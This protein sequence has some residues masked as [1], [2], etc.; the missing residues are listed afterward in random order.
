MAVLVNRQLFYLEVNMDKTKNNTEELEMTDAMVRQLDLIDNATYDVCCRYLGI[1]EEER[2]NLSPWNMQILAQVRESIIDALLQ[3]GK[4][5]CYPYI[6]SNKEDSR[7]CNK[8]DCHCER[9]VRDDESFPILSYSFYEFKRHP[10]YF[11]RIGLDM[12]EQTKLLRQFDVWY[13]NTNQETEQYA[14]EYAVITRMLLN[15]AIVLN[16]KYLNLGEVLDELL[17]LIPDSKKQLYHEHFLKMQ[18][19]YTPDTEG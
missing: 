2:E 11:L 12:R 1:P 10:L 19:G 17:L 9:C 13:G 4:P 8:R 5:V 15:N 14:L 6:E 18:G 16:P 7:Y 3:F